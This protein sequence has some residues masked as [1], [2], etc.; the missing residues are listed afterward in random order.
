M[1]FE[2]LKARILD[3]VDVEWFIDVMGITMEDL[4]DKFEDEIYLKRHLFSE[5]DE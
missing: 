3:V 5:L 4:V 1:D 2:D